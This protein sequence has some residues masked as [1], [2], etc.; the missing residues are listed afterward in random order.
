[1]A[2]YLHFF[3]SSR[4]C[5]WHRRVLFSY[6]VVP[7]LT[8]GGAALWFKLPRSRGQTGVRPGSGRDQAG[9]R[10]G[11]GRGQAG[12]R[13]GSGVT[14]SVF[15]TPRA[16]QKLIFGPTCTMRCGG[17][18]RGNKIPW[19][20]TNT[21]CDGEYWLRWGIRIARGQ[22]WASSRASAP[23]VHGVAHPDMQSFAQKC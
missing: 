4:I 6:R 2:S 5:L 17:G 19:G 18:V 23:E 14:Q 22:N 21:A 7:W 8:Q 13:P 3:V 16:L 10:P 9:V 11:S 15:S 20:P 12:I 1:M